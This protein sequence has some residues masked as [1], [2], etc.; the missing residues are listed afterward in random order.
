VVTS[1]EVVNRM[2]AGRSYTTCHGGAYMIIDGF[3]GGD[4]DLAHGCIGSTSFDPVARLENGHLRAV[5]PERFTRAASNRNLILVQGYVGQHSRQE[6]KLR[7]IDILAPFSHQSATGNVPDR[8]GELELPM[9]TIEVDG[10][11]STVDFDIGGD[12]D[13]ETTIMLRAR[14]QQRS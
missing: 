11:R 10:D 2:V 6:W 1:A 5:V 13:S 9:P 7:I 12:V 8:G 4:P 3:H 14:S